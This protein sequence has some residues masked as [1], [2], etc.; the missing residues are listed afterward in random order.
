MRIKSLYKN[1][2]SKQEMTNRRGIFIT[3]TISKL[4]EKV[5]QDKLNL[6]MDECQSGGRKNRSTV[7]NWI[8]LGAILDQNRWLGKSTYIIVADAE[9]C[10]DRLWLKDCL[11]DLHE[12]GVRE[13]EVSLIHQMNMKAKINID[14]PVGKTEQFEVKEIVKQGTIYGP[15][16][17]CINSSKINDMTECTSSYIT[18]TLQV[19]ALAYVDDIMAAGDR[20]QIEK[21]GKN[22][23]EMESKKKYT[24]NNSNGKSHY[25]VLKTSKNSNR[26]DEE[27]II[28]VERGKVTRTKSYKYLGNWLDESATITRQIEEMS[29]K[30]KGMIAE[31]KRIGD[32]KYT[33]RMS[34]NVI[35]TIYEMTIL[36]ALIFNLEAWTNVRKKDWQEIE[37]IQAT[38]LKS[39]FRLPIS[40]PY[41]GLLV[42][43]GIWNIQSRI[44]YKK[45]MIWQNI[46]NSEDTRLSRKV[47]ME[48]KE[49]KWEIGWYKELT[50]IATKHKIDLTGTDTLMKSEWKK[51][52]KE[53]IATSI[54]EEAER[55]I[56]EMKK[57]EW[58]KGQKLE[59]QKYLDNRGIT[60]VSSMLKTKLHMQDIGNNLG[61][62]HKCIGCKEE[63][64]LN[65]LTKC[66]KA[67]RK[68]GYKLNHKWLNS[69]ESNEILAVAQYVKKYTEIRT[70][71]NKEGK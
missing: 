23:K 37:K 66:I 71:E 32:E 39:L 1:K 7:D 54:G 48:Q 13:R 15:L 8:I 47:I 16:L 45:L 70:S 52:V 49:R 60:E 34:T 56:S 38:C 40:T 2:G 25:M 55:K 46:K 9:K 62:N 5:M 24:F 17:C 4:F 26:N 22:L 31:T 61:N 68:V 59:R 21:V 10:F 57:L 29:N 30:V 50:E 43:L 64:N 33:G 28:E 18:P 3:S 41:W 14:T 67:E 51:L 6:R 11:V 58:L 19:G 44:E 35:L 53:R 42:E 36:P 27:A 63:E 12:A 69:Q 20:K 65:H